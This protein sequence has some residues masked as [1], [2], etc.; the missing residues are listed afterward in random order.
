MRILVLSSVFPSRTRPTYGVFVKER[1]RH[2]AARADV[3]VVAPVPWFPLNRRFR[4]ESVAATPLAE[5]IDGIV[6]YHPRF[7]CAPVLGKSLDA[8]LYVAGVAPFLLWLRRKF[9][10]DLID[11][12]F[13]YPDGVA[14]VVLG[15]LFGR[16]TVVTLRGTHDTRHAG[17]TIRRIQ[18]RWALRAATC[19]VA[20]SESL[21]KF[22]VSLGVD[23]ERIRVIGNGV[24]RQRFT[25][26]DQS[27]A[28]EQ[29]GL[30]HGPVILLAVGNLVE[31]KGHHRVIEILPDLVNR[32]PELLYI[33]IGAEL[34]GSHYRSILDELIRRHAL[35]PHIR[36]LPPRPHH[37]IPL[38]MAA[39]DLFCLATRS[40]GWCNAIME[41]LAC[42]LPVVTTR[43]GGNP[44][45]VRD[46]TD[47]FLVPF[48]DGVKFT[49]AILAALEHEW[50]RA[51]IARR[52][53]GWEHVAEQVLDELTQACATRDRVSGLDGGQADTSLVAK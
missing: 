25:P 2:V 32:R 52:I 45:V 31:G 33:A 39:A 16:P 24:D 7:P 47:G 6:V 22:A 46:G 38:W 5:T 35:E 19:L 14:A 53:Q 17:Y 44:E 28:R 43:V 40:E 10:F 29:L 23:R 8:L 1:I 3:V 18:I 21:Q 12:H 50:D 13:T 37:E 20:V 27:R 49:A 26:T 34:K 48:W 11:A 41:A 51:G 4:G 36:I 42:G 9:P 15:K 30:P